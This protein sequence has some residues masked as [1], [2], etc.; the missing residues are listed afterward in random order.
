MMA[1]E[2]PTLRGSA[3]HS[4]AYYGAREGWRIGLQVN[5]DSDALERSNWD[6]ITA[7][8]AERFPSHWSRADGQWAIER[9]HHWAVGWVDYLLVRPGTAAHDAAL[10]WV[11]KLADYPVADDEHFG[12]LERAEEWCAR[13]DRGMR[14][15]HPLAGCQ[16]RSEDDAEEIRWRWSQRNPPEHGWRST[17]PPSGPTLWDAQ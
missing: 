7:D 12:A 4:F 5:R 2:L 10:V 3:A 9:M 11:R 17:R 14:S 8:M 6:V 13:C 1:A 16:F 15:E